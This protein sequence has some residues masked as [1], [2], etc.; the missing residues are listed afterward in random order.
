MDIRPGSKV[1]VELTELPR[2]EAARKTLARLFRKDPAVA[3]IQRKITRRR[4]SW[5]E[6]VRGGNYWHHQ[7][8]SSPG[9]TLRPGVKYSLLATVDVVRDLQSVADCV[10]VSAGGA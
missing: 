3:R 7:M 1:I 4:P 9:V 5:E 8:Q 6:W 2:R 10:K